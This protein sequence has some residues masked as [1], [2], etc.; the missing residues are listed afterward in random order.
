V[1]GSGNGADRFRHIRLNE[2]G[3]RLFSDPVLSRDRSVSC[4]NCHDPKR[5]FT[6]GEV[7]ARGI[8]GPVG[9]R[10]TPTIAGSAETLVQNAESLNRKIS[11]FQVDSGG[12]TPL[13]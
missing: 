3:K 2:Q 7:R 10:N 8:D 4:Q 6:D 11:A 1:E 12:E 13:S 5:A 9:P